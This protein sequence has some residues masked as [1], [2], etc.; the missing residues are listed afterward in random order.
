MM[1]PYDFTSNEQPLP[2]FLI[3]LYPNT[4]NEITL[5]RTYCGVQLSDLT[6]PARDASILN[7][8]G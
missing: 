3:L 8:C 4:I 1:A 2:W 5:S 7:V 6:R